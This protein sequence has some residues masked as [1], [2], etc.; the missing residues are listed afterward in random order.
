MMPP[1]TSLTAGLAKLDRLIATRRAQLKA[2]VGKGRL[3]VETAASYDEEMAALRRQV[4][5]FFDRAPEI[6]ALATDIERARA[7][8][9]ASAA[10]LRTH[11]AVAPV[12]AAF[13]EAAITV[14][15]ISQDE[16]T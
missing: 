14:R 6:K 7:L 10:D 3:G 9:M 16:S 5:W 4:A 12:L 2:Q 11:P 15:A 1:R 8:R 13:P